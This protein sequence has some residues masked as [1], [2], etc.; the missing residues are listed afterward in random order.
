VKRISNKPV[1]FVVRLKEVRKYGLC[2]LGQLKKN[3]EANLRN[4]LLQTIL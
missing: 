3:P 4:P 2:A 1:R